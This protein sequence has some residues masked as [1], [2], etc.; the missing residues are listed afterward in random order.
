MSQMEMK[1]IE[2]RGLFES[3][4]TVGPTTEL[5]VRASKKEIALANLMARRK[6]FEITGPAHLRHTRTFQTDFR[7]IR[8]YMPGDR[9]RDIDWKAASRLTKLMTKEFEKET[10]L[11]TMLMVDTSLSMRELVKRR[12]KLDHS[13]ALA[14][15]VAIVMDQQHHPVGLLTFDE[16]S[17]REH[18]SPG[19]VDVEEIVMSL[20]KL[21]NPLETGD[22]PGPQSDTSLSSV[23]DVQDFISAVSPFLHKRHKVTSKEDGVTG[24]FK[25]LSEMAAYE[26]TG[27]LIVIIT[28][29]ETNTPSMIKALKIAIGMKHRV[30]LVSPFSWPYHLEGRDLHPDLLE[31]VYRDLESKQSVIKAVTASGVRVIEIDSRERGDKVISGLRRLSR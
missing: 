20:F 12:S 7:S 1:V 27:L 5:F 21:P 10:N 4:V 30:V 28:D 6:Q 13:I 24:I 2:G 11:P 15:Q 8:D 14:L 31:R 16:N 18:I 19:S 25:A 9:F 22:Y 23:E 26:E 17:V 29:L 3:I